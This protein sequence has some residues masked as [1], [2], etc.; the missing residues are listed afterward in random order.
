MEFSNFKVDRHR[1]GISGWPFYVVT[2]DWL[3]R[4]G[5]L[6][7]MVATVPN[8]HKDKLT[9]ALPWAAARLTKR[10]GAPGLAEH[11]A[12][13]GVQIKQQGQQGR[14]QHQRQAR[15]QPVR[16]HLGTHQRGQRQS[17]RVQQHS[18][19]DDKVVNFSLCDN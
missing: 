3:K 12:G 14:E 11:L 4:E 15:Q 8:E 6:R 10:S 9:R 18:E 2:F 13:L 7:H 16:Q 1:N 5:N 17:L 19:C